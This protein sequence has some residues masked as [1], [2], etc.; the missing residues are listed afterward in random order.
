MDKAL[1]IKNLQSILFLQDKNGYFVDPVTNHIDPRATAEIC[2]SLLYIGK[3]SQ[4]E[5][6]FNWLVK[7]QSK[8]GSWNE[9][10]HDGF[11]EES[12]VATSI[13]GR[14]M[15]IAYIKTENDIYLKS[16]LKSSKYLIS[17]EF[18]PGYFIKSYKHYGDV[19]NV[20]ACCAAFFYKLY[21]ITKDTKLLTIRD[22]AIFNIIRYQF[23]DGF[24]PYASRILTSPYEYHLNLKDPHYHAI[25]M[26]F[27]ILSDPKL[28]NRYLKLSIEKAI[29]CMKSNIASGNFDWSYGYLQFSLGLNGG[30]AYAYFCLKYIDNNYNWLRKFDVNE[31]SL[32]KRYEHINL[33]FLIKRFFREIFN[34]G[35]DG[36]PNYSF[37]VRMFRI[38][39]I[40]GRIRTIY[41][42]NK[43]SL[44]YSAQMYDCLTEY[45]LVITK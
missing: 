29:K 4:A 22:R 23:K 44:Y 3:K 41:L 39:G 34:F 21:E 5:N 12:C 7:I 43:I 13:I 33:F 28:E 27:L 32:I 15:L 11:N 6:G 1:L 9:V 45:F 19:L 37:W 10:L 42:R 25:T 24:Y 31:N 36:N 38:K 2:K 35:I 14:L 26:Y 8:N 16:A 40:I 17:K 18:S 20:N 30:Y